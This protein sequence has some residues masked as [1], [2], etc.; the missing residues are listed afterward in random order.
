M[1][2]VLI[3]GPR[4]SRRGAEYRLQVANLYRESFVHYFDGP[5]GTGSGDLVMERL[6]RALDAER[7]PSG[8]LLTDRT[9]RYGW[10]ALAGS[11]RAVKVIAEI[12]PAEGARRWDEVVWVGHPG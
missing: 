6:G 5:V 12:R 9:F 7:V 10:E 11:F 4:R 1:A 2:L 3:L 8:A